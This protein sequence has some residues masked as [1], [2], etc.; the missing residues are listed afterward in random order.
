MSNSNLDFRNHQIDCLRKEVERQ[1]EIQ[2]QRHIKEIQDLVEKTKKCYIQQ[3]V[4]A[5][6]TKL[7]KHLKKKQKKLMKKTL[8]N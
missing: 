3:Q 5:K 2:R 4:K 7:I 1:I 6:Y 8:V